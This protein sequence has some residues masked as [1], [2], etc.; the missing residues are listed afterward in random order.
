MRLVTERLATDRVRRLLNM[1]PSDSAERVLASILAEGLQ[2][3]ME[4]E[5]I[6][7]AW[8]A[9]V[10]GRP[11]QVDSTLPFEEVVESLVAVKKDAA[12]MYRDAARDCPD[13]HI[14]ERLKQ[15]ANQEDEQADVLGLLNP[16]A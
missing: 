9:R 10:N 7:E 15:L 16:P 4:L 3:M 11:L 5:E 6:L 14:A 2:H 8:E 12:E 1:A 13:P